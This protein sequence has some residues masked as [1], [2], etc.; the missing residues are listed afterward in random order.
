MAATFKLAIQLIQHEVRKQWRER[1]ALRR[2]LPA[3]LEQPVVENTGRQVAPD[4]PEYSPIGDTGRH[5]GHQ[6]VVID[7]VEELRQVY[8]DNELIAFG[9]IACA[10]ATACWAER[11]GRKP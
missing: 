3:R 11:P 8:I 7:P 10:C 6:P 9:N 5:A 2:A 4:E 1:T